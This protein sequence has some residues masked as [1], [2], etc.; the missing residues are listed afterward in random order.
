MLK[1]PRILLGWKFRWV[2]KYAVYFQLHILT[3]YWFISTKRAK[4]KIEARNGKDM[5]NK[6]KRDGKR[7]W[8]GGGQGGG[9]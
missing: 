5:R 7:G 4:M 9:I 2:P 3:V 1:S 6:K 8:G